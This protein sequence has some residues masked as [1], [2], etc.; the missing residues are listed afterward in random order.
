MCK[1]RKEVIPKF[2]PYLRHLM[3]STECV[4]GPVRVLDESWVFDANQAF[5]VL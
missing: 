3:N 2:P 1:V 4:N 5:T